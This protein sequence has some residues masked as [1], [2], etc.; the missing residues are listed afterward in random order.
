EPGESYV[1]NTYGAY[2][3]RDS[4]NNILYAEVASANKPVLSPTNSSHLYV[5]T[6]I[7]DGFIGIVRVQVEIGNVS[8]DFELY[9]RFNYTPFFG[10]DEVNL[11]KDE[12]VY[13]LTKD[14]GVDDNENYD[15]ISYQAIFENKT[16]V[17]YI[18][19]PAYINA[20][21]DFG[22]CK[23]EKCISLETSDGI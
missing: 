11:L 21:F 16:D 9:K 17:A 7:I 19:K 2:S 15:Y 3:F 20:T 10:E 4:D 12:I 22:E 6:P 8:N 23:N 13:D 14:N 1:M 18:N 5:S